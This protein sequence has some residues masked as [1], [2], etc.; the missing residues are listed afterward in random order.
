MNKDKKKEMINKRVEYSQKYLDSK[1]EQRN[2]Y[3]V[4]IVLFILILLFLL[5]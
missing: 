3:I 5:I 2:Y 4:T 1:K